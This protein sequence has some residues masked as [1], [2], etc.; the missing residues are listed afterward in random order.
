MQGRDEKG[1]REEMLFQ[2]GGGRAL[3]M[4]EGPPLMHPQHQAHLTLLWKEE[5]SK[6]L[7]FPPPSLL[8]SLL[9][10]DGET[11]EEEETCSP[12]QLPVKS[13]VICKSRF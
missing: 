8:L 13:W 11:E 9:S 4:E 5:F 2:R 10:C 3:R 7:R 12:D 1:A 6:E